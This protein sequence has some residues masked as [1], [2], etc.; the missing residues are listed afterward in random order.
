MSINDRPEIRETFAAFRH[1]EAELTYSVAGGEGVPAR[2][3]I[4]TGGR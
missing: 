4:I 3:L 1:D 2:E